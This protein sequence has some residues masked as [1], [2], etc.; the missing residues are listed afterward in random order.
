MKAEAPMLHRLVGK[1][2]VALVSIGMILTPGCGDD[3]ALSTE[4][5]IAAANQICAGGNER[6]DAIFEGLFT[7]GE[8]SEEDAA[9]AVDQLVVE[10]RSQVEEIDALEPPDELSD[11][12]DAMVEAAREAADEMEA[13]GPALLEAESDPFAEVNAMAGEI[14]LDECADDDEEEEEEGGFEEEAAAGATV[15]DVTA[16]EYAFALGSTSVAAGPVAFTMTNAGEEDHELGFG[17]LADGVTLEQLLAFEGDPEAEGLATDLGGECC[18]EPGGAGVVNVDLQPG[19]WA[20]VC[21][22]DSPEG[23]PHAVLGMATT[24]EVT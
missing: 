2:L 5:F 19:T 1:W 13:A 18:L 9:A 12:V 8:P 24:I 14:G 16:T 15:V 21:F 7:S 3:D 20:L 11:D 17:R 23:P 10:V 6:I 22:L 4:E